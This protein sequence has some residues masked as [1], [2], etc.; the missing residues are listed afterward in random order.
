MNVLSN[1]LLTFAFVKL[2][3]NFRRKG[4][5]HDVLVIHFVVVDDIFGFMHIY[6]KWRRIC[7][8]MAHEYYC[9]RFESKTKKFL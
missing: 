7:D 5:L 4:T 6:K 9:E 1:I 2:N 3:K 8:G